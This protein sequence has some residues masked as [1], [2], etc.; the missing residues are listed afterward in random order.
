MVSAAAEPHRARTRKPALMAAG[1]VA[2]LGAGQLPWHHESGSRCALCLHL[3][4]ENVTKF[5]G[6][7]VSNHVSKSLHDWKNTIAHMLPFIST[8]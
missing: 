6:I 1:A 5:Q 8:G 7:H 3:H 2:S 4:S